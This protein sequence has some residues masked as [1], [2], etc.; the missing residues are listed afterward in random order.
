MAP[1]YTQFVLS[2]WSSIYPKYW[3]TLTPYHTCPKIC[4]SSLYNRLIRLKT[5]GEW[6]TVRGRSAVSDVA[7]LCL[8][9]PIYETLPGILGK[10]GIRHFI[11]GEQG[12]KSLKLKGT[13]EQRQLGGT[14]NIENQDFDLGEQ[15]KMLIFSREQGNRYPPPLPSPLHHL[16]GPHLSQCL[17]LYSVIFCLV[18]TRLFLSHKQNDSTTD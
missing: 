8:F 12:N 6:Q 9:Q 4:A 5:A 11:S 18:G 3:D 14:G 17:G 15:G 1:G 16:G 10:R 13:G 7:L 2:K